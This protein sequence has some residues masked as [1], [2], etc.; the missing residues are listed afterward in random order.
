M[1]KKMMKILAGLT[2]AISL[3]ACSGQKQ[4]DLSILTTVSTQIGTI[5]VS[6]GTLEESRFFSAA[7]MLY[8][9]GYMNNLKK[10][11]IA[12]EKDVPVQDAVKCHI[13]TRNKNEDIYVVAPYIK[14][15]GF[16]LT[17]SGDDL[18]FINGMQAVIDKTDP[19]GGQQEE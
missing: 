8:F 11:T 9:S 19:L 15:D 2:M 16:W 1:L 13:R 5:E 17:G 14:V 6:G 4:M 18:L 10:L 7:E 12:D 3:T